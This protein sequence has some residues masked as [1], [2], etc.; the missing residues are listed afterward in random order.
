MFLIDSSE[1]IFVL[2]RME[3]IFRHKLVSNS[4]GILFE[5]HAMQIKLISANSFPPFGQNFKKGLMCGGVQMV[6]MLCTIMDYHT[7]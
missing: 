6:G 4:N 2:F 7:L 3:L 1:L 5:M